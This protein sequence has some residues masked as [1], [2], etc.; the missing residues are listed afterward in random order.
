MMG[1]MKAALFV[2]SLSD[3]DRQ[4]LESGL[5]SRDAI[6]LR[7]CQILLASAVSWVL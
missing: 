5:R 1:A 4:R 6:E 3:A 2:G 7:R